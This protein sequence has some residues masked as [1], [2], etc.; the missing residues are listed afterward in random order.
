MNIYIICI[1]NTRYVYI[2]DYI[3]YMLGYIYIYIY[4]GYRHIS[5]HY[6]SLYC[7]LQILCLFAN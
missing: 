7:A 1:T 2:L 4:V 5:F 3:I 6:A